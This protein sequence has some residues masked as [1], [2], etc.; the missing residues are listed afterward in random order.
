MKN[1]EK[2][3]IKNGETPLHGE[4]KNTDSLKNNARCPLLTLDPPHKAG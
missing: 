3:T 2:K 4:E 1:S